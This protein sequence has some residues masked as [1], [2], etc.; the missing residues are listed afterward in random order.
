MSI[1]PLS[2]D[3]RFQFTK[4]KKEKKKKKK[5]K[6]EKKVKKKKR[7]K[8]KKEDDLAP[9]FFFGVWAQKEAPKTSMVVGVRFFLKKTKNF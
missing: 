4:L 5:E 3:P 9:R 7:N 6:K 8:I 2:R 1:N